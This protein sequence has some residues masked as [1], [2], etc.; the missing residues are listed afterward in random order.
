IPADLSMS[1]QTTSVS[2][3]VD[4]VSSVSPDVSSPG[5]HAPNSAVALSNP[6]DFNH[7]FFLNISTHLS[8]FVNVFNNTRI[9]LEFF[10]VNRVFIFFSKKFYLI[11]E[12]RTV[13]DK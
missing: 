13:I 9:A 8:I 5:P 6:K 11:K 4:S 2:P 7:V 1:S 12:N 3:P 10:K